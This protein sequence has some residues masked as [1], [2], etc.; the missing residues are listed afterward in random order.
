MEN[1]AGK[2]S[3][4]G[5]DALRRL[6][7]AAQYENERPRAYGDWRAGRNNMSLS[8][9]QQRFVAE[10]L[11]DLNA[12]QAAI[13]AGYSQ[14]TARNIGQENLA[15]PA[16]RAALAAG[17]AKQLEEITAKEVLQAM[18]RL[19][20]VDVKSFYDNAGN[21]K[22]I[23]AWTPIQSAQ[24]SRVETV[25][26]ETGDGSTDTVVKLSFWSKE[27]ALDMLGKHF[28]VLSEQIN[29]TIDADLS[30]RLKAGRE[31]NA[32]ATRARDDTDAPDS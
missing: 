10:Y 2:S 19:A 7:R 5:R 21:P 8:P 12:T 9:K 32:V 13:R 26:R 22:P 14:K 29:V 15:K 30:R 23:Q 1:H 18:G 3:D 4:Q 16:I 24:V 17:K 20:R 11:V 27:K 6:Q 28:G 31:R 25:T